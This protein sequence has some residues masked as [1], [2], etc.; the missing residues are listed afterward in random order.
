MRPLLACNTI[1]PCMY[2]LYCLFYGVPRNSSFAST[3]P[4]SVSSASTP[5]AFGPLLCCH[6]RFWVLPVFS[7]TGTIIVAEF[8]HVES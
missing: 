2:V 7:F 4:K 5:R 1:F 8:S 6:T 3:L